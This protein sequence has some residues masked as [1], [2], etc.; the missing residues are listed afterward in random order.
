MC[1]CQRTNHLW[2]PGLIQCSCVLGQLQRPSH[3]SELLELRPYPDHLPELAS[4]LPDGLASLT[5]LNPPALWLLFA[6]S[7]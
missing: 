7:D 6:L 1:S 5:S 4:P 2:K 3:W